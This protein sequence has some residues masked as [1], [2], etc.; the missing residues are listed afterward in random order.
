MVAMT[1]ISPEHAN[2]AFDLFDHGTRQRRHEA[3]ANMA[4]TLDCDPWDLVAIVARPGSSFGVALSLAV[5]DGEDLLLDEHGTAQPHLAVLP[6]EV[7]ERVLRVEFPGVVDQFES[8]LGRVNVVL[9]LDDEHVRVVHED[10]E[11]GLVVDIH[12]DLLELAGPDD[13]RLELC[14]PPAD[15][16]FLDEPEDPQEEPDD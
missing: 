13:P 9:V 3:V 5:Y 12:D 6:R 2:E 15:T 16:S 10:V 1:S 14:T 4:V 7:A 11:V 8:Q